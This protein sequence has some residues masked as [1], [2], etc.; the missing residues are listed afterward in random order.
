MYTLKNENEVV[1]NIGNFKQILILTQKKGKIRCWNIKV[2][3]EG[4]SVP[5]YIY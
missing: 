2:P 3:L 1:N 5:G 4:K